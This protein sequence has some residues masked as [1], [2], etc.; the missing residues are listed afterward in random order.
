MLGSCLSSPSLVP[1]WDENL[2][3][4]N[5]QP[6][7]IVDTS[8]CYILA[9]PRFK[10]NCELYSP[11]G[12]LAFP[13]ATAPIIPQ[14]VADTEGRTFVATL[15]FDRLG[16]KAKFLRAVSK[17]YRKLYVGSMP[18]MPEKAKFVTG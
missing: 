2:R 6:L 11:S 18:S 15:H 13:S 12:S 7:N 5:L 8:K 1:F 14:D 17:E 16:M 3:E 9:V 4:F 10:A